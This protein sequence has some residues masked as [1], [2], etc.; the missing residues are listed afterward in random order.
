MKSNVPLDYAVFQLSP[1]RS[2]CEL[3]VSHDGTMEKLTSGLVKPFV[4]HLKVAEEQVALAVKSIKLEVERHQNAE[5]WFTK[6]TLERF[7]RFVSTPEVLE[8]V[9]T[10]DAEM[11][12]LEAARRIYSQGAGDRGSGGDGAGATA[13]SDATKKELLRAID[14]RLMAVRQDLTTACARASAAGFNPDTVSELWLFADQFGAHRL[15]EACEKFTSLCQQRPDLITLWKLRVDDHAL[16]FSSGS[17]MS[18]DD[19]SADDHC[20]QSKPS[21][22]ANKSS[23]FTFPLCRSSMGDSNNDVLKETE[24]KDKREKGEEPVSSDS[25]NNINNYS[26]TELEKSSFITQLTSQPTTR[27][28][29]VQDRINLFENKQKEISSSSSPSISGGGGG[30]GSGG[31]PVVVGKSF[32]LLRQSSDVSSSTGFKK[33]VLRRWSGASDMS[34]DLGGEKK[35]LPDSNASTPTSATAVSSLPKQQQQPGVSSSSSWV[36]ESENKDPK[37]LSGIVKSSLAKP[38]IKR[39]G[40]DCDI[41]DECESKKE[42]V[43]LNEPNRTTVGFR[44]FPKKNKQFG[45]EKEHIIEQAQVPSGGEEPAAVGEQDAI[46]GNKDLVGQ[47]NQ[48]GFPGSRFRGG[49]LDGEDCQV[50]H[51]VAEDAGQNQHLRSRSR[52]SQRKTMDVAFDSEDQSQPA[53]H[54]KEVEVGAQRKWKSFEG[55]DKVR[56]NNL[57][58]TEKQ[59]DCV[60]A[61]VEDSCSLK[62]KIQGHGSDSEY[63]KKPQ[64]RRDDGDAVFGDS[65]VG[66]VGKNAPGNQ[67]SLSATTPSTDQAQRV[68]Q[69]K[70]N[71]GLNDEL[72][73][74]AN[75]LEKLFAEHKLRAPGDQS[76]LTRRSKAV[77]M[78]TKHE[79]SSL[80]A[81]PSFEVSP[82]Q[83]T[84]ARMVAE[85]SRGSSNIKFNSSPTGKASS[86]QDYD[87]TPKQ[88]I[89]CIG[90]LDD[91]RGKFYHKYMQK[92]DAKLREEWSLKRDEK[93]A[94]MK[95]MQDSLERSKAELKTKLAA[96]AD[97]QDS[98]LQ[99]R[100]RAEKLRS[101]SVRSAARRQQPI[102]A[103][104]SEEDEDKEEFSNLKPYGRDL[105]STEL[106]LGDSSSRSAQ[107]KKVLPDKSMASSTPRTSAVPNNRSSMKISNCSAGRR[108]LQSDNPLAQSV[109]SFS[110]LRKENTK[111]S[112]GASKTTARS[113]VRNYARSKSGSEEKSRQS[114]SLR[115]SSA[116]TVELNDF[117]SL[118]SDAVVLTSLKLDKG[119][120][121]AGEEFSKNMGSKSFLRKGNGISAVVRSG[122]IKSR[123]SVA[124]ETIDNEDEELMDLAKEEEEDDFESVGGDDSANLDNSNPRLSQES[125]KSVNSGSGNSDAVR[126]NSQVDIASGAELPVTMSSAFH[127]TGTVQDSPG[128]SPR[129]WNIRMQNPF[130]FSNEI[131]DI[132]ASVDSPLGS[133]AYWN[134]HPLTQ[135]DPEAARMRKKWGAAQKPIVI[136]DPSH[137]QSRKD[138]T[139]GLK[140]FL[141]FGRKNRATESLADWISATTSEGDDDTEDGRDLANRSSEDLRKSRMGFSHGH[142]SDDGFNEADFNEQVQALQS[143][144]PTPPTHFKLREEHLSGSSLKA[145]RSFFSLSNFRSKGSDSKPR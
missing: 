33:A 65:Q 55:A 39:G 26:T 124:L 127:A 106:F 102:E 79:A 119:E 19:P 131:S 27:R 23:S 78:Q 16:R 21:T 14:V 139:R 103:F 136:T 76:N 88:N 77:D 36:V 142:A 141:K 138:V 52:A 54:H 10:F 4:T 107:T 12:Q 84:A 100:C 34:I 98:A 61:E 123:S 24:D 53:F 81:K 11:S 117:S 69:S 31:R 38:E 60:L 144:I 28:L 101:F 9:N 108:K 32:E 70:G 118:D 113:Q 62:M 86:D 114:Q 63:V 135:N 56:R 112:S 8:M 72:Q 132:D 129:S 43:E 90:F 85:P 133:P 89:H 97:R 57:D 105:I 49:R 17:D 116:N 73:M 95:A 15:S 87:S 44:S 115:K 145:P 29:S 46:G 99:A 47:K 59:L 67:E 5:A 58:P 51:A 94:R 140:R 64:G 82:A 22:T 104:L 91:S 74:K 40:G 68:R 96:S 48:F 121:E 3:F 80:Y 7:V 109:P 1:R 13:A 126:C 50:P 137:C 125:E 30:G 120:T 25:S 111:P 2:R 93:E 41:N 71:Q 6:G 134:S 42:E 66:V 20:H 18:L 130:S 75:E 122:I 110:D 83:L 92:R 45:L 35:E 37:E 128:E 143:S